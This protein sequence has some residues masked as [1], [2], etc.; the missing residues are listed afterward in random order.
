MAAKERKEHSAAKPQP[1]IG[2]EQKQ[3]KETKQEGRWQNASQSDKSSSFP[4]FASV[5]TPT[6]LLED[7]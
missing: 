7:D 4:S 3:T 6:N 1:K 2:I 5:R